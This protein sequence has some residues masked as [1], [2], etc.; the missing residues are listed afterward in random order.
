MIQKFGPLES[1]HCKGCRN[2]SDVDGLTV[3]NEGYETILKARPGNPTANC[4][5]ER[6]NGEGF[7]DSSVT[8]VDISN[9]I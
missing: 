4:G 3:S 5:V 9:G 7:W 6:R 2:R 8:S 1:S